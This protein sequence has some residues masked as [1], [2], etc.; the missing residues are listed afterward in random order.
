MA[1]ASELKAVRAVA[2][3]RALQET[4]ALARVDGAG[5]AVRRVETLQKAE[6]ARQE[7]RL[8]GWTR[9]L[10]LGGPPLSDLWAAAFDAGQAELSGLAVRQADAEVG[11]DAARA[12]WRAAS[13][14]A[15]AASDLAK[16][17]ARRFTRAREE[18]ALA[19]VAD[20]AARKGGPR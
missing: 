16:T 8:D 1:R 9:S 7:A 10:T 15:N 14:R 5:R 20:R 6:R 19:E 13:A 11:L 17:T 3:L 4:A 2:T 18:R 12:D